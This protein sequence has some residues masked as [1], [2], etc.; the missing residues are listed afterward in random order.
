MRKNGFEKNDVKVGTFVEYLISLFP[1]H[2]IA[3]FGN[4]MDTSV[5]LIHFIHFLIGR[6]PTFP[7]K[8]LR[9]LRN[10]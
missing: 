10:Y 4:I 9:G 3:L 8:S 6:S 5:C 2:P 1:V 7:L